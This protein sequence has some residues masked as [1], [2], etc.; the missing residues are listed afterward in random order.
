MRKGTGKEGG[1][2]MREGGKGRQNEGGE[3]ETK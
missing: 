2:K 3:G 1:D